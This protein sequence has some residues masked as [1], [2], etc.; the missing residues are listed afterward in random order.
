ASSSIATSWN[1]SAFGW[2]TAHFGWWAS[3][4]RSA[5]STSTW[6]TPT[7]EST[8]TAA[9]SITARR[10]RCNFSF[11]NDGKRRQGQR[12]G[13]DAGLLALSLY[14][15]GNSPSVQSVTLVEL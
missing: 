1:G 9:F 4:N 15:D 5:R 6:L 8:T 13:K 12:N 7:V 2:A 10:S 14:S 3:P 11:R